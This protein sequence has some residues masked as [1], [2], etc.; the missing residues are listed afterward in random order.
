MTGQRFGAPAREGA[1]IL[2][3]ED[4]APTRQVLARELA[5]AGYRVAEAADGRSAIERFGARRPDLVLLDLGLPDIDGLE[6]IRAIRRDARTPIVILSGRYEE[7]EKVAALDRG[8]DD[9]VTKPFGVDELR[10]RIRVAIRH[11]AGP[12]ADGEG[13]LAI[14]PIALDAG[15]HQVRVAGQPGRPV[16]A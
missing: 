8:A 9:Y 11:A 14:G 12:A 13:R 6:V 2:I 15:R 16:A 1:L 10:A 7:R 3:V 4:D 5:G